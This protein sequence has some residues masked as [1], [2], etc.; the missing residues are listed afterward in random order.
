MAKFNKAFSLSQNIRG[1]LW[2]NAK[3]LSDVEKALNISEQTVRVA[4]SRKFLR[5]KKTTPQ[6]QQIVNYLKKHCEGF[7]EWA[8]KNLQLD[9]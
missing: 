7:K 2:V 8:D 5:N 9:S 3:N 6:D 1:G 4:I